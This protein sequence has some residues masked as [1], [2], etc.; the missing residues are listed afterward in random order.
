[1]NSPQTAALRFVCAWLAGMVLGL[2]YGFLRP[3]GARHRTLAD[4]LFLAGV[5]PVWLLHSFAICRGDIRIG[6]TAGLGLGFL[7]W[8]LTASRPLRPVFSEFWR[9]FLYPWK[10]IL[11]FCK[12]IVKKP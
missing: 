11:F 1:M 10:K 7:L 12:K 9:V 6:Q 2:Y 3:L 5:I 8:E 4:A